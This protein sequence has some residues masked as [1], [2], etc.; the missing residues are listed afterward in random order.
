MSLDLLLQMLRHYGLWGLLAVVM[1]FILLKGQIT[2]RY[3]RP[4]K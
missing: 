4:K 1:I 3:P 2:F